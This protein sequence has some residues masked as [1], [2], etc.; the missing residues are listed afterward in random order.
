MT[1]MRVL[2]Q[3]R[4]RWR[5]GKKKKER[6]GL[7]SRLGREEAALSLTVNL[8]IRHFCVSS[9]SSSDGNASR[10]QLLPPALFLP[11]APGRGGAGCGVGSRHPCASL[12]SQ[13]LHTPCRESSASRLSYRCPADNSLVHEPSSN[14][15]WRL[16]SVRSSR[17][18]VDSPA[19]G[20]VGWIMDSAASERRRPA[21]DHASRACRPE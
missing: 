12:T 3:R 18:V 21:S 17:P 16:A 11:S 10:T 19:A 6:P 9:P 5:T 14:L 15:V 8:I 4:G 13:L 1:V 2:V 7:C 20:V